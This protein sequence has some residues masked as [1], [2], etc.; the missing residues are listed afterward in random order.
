MT[1]KYREIP[2]E[3]EA[4]AK[5][6]VLLTGGTGYVGSALRRYVRDEGHDVRLL[7]RSGSERKL[8]ARDAYEVTSG[9]IFN[10]NACLRACDGC[11]AVIH[12]VGIIREYPSRGI[13]FDQHHRVATANILDAARRT[14][15]Q[16]F[17]HL[18]ALGTRA[19]AASMYHK[20]KFAA[21]ELVRGSSLRWTIFRPSWIMGEGDHGTRQI[22]DLIRRRVV[23]LINGGR[24]LLQPVALHDACTVMAKALHMPETQGKVYDVGGPDRVT[25]KALVEAIAAEVGLAF[26]TV[27][28]PAAMLRPVVTLL[29]RVPSFP[30]TRDQLRMLCED[31]VCEIDPYVKTFRIEP[32]SLKEIL[33]TLFKRP[34]R[35][36]RQPV[37][38]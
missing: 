21:E 7:V 34:A 20:T 8:D 38:L 4:P 33:P 18:S 36:G 31:N 32:K 15:V 25:F 24:M 19:N 22:A 3:G 14:G 1:P 13:T 6:K 12:L 27:A 2:F 11:D 16:R 9:D 17:I 26:R 10:T 28:V 30:L 37:L 5:M 35:P 29:E 23:P